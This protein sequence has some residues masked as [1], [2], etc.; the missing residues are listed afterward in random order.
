MNIRTR[1]ITLETIS[2]LYLSESIQA[3]GSIPESILQ[4]TRNQEQDINLDIMVLHD[5]ST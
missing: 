5:F 1:P 3:A 4:L 2:F